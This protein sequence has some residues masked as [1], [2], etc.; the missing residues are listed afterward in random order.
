L[1]VPMTIPAI[2]AE[3][4]AEVD[5]LMI[6][7][8]HIE[9]LQMMENAGRNFADCAQTLTKT[10]SRPT[11]LILCGS[12]NN[13]GGGLVA[14]RHLI[15]RGFQVEIILTHEEDQLKT[16]PKHQWFILKKMGV[17]LAS[18][19]KINEVDLVLDAIIGYGLRGSPRGNAAKW[20]EKINAA[21]IPTLSLDVPSG[22]DLTMGTPLEPCIQ[23]SATLTLALPKTG[24]LTPEA[25][26]FVGD[27]YLADIS[28]PNHLYK[29]LNLEVGPIF[30]KQAIIKL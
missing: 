2:T 26:P 5:R 18:E 29:T 27:L 16:I 24:L 14:A 12:G 20:I 21:N 8:Y 9:L 25:K 30:K 1:E 19:P 28:V 11:F 17:N 13:G 15:N 4:M 10:D 7:V 22:L 23:A 6:H 3:Q